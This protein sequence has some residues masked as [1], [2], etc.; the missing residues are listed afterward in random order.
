MGLA[1]AALALGT[2]IGVGTA[3][4]PIEQFTPVLNIRVGILLLLAAGSIVHYFWLRSNRDTYP[5]IGTVVA[6]CRAAVILIGFEL[7][8]AEIH[9]F[10]RHQSGA[11]SEH[12]AGN[13]G[14]FIEIM[15]FAT[16]WM[17]YSFP[18]VRYGLRNRALT[19]LLAGLGSVGVAT[20][21][22]AIAAFA[23]VPTGWLSLA[24]SLRPIVLLFLGAGLFLHMRWLRE[25]QRAYRWLDAV[26]VAM[27]A[28]TVLLGF[29]LLTAQTRDAVQ[30]QIDVA[31]ARGV[32]S[33]VDRWQNLQQV[34]L[35]VIWLLYAIG[36]LI[37]GLWR[38]TRWIRL[39][40]M[41]LLGFIILK[42]FLYDL[43]FLG[44]A[45]R[46]ISFA[47]LGVILLGVSYLYQRYR[48][49]LFDMS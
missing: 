40:A 26:L 25:G 18:L 44:P 33:D 38:R 14:L 32:P 35:S 17:L 46:S 4:Q 24:L 1:I 16:V 19:V 21:A 31:Q 41:A 34:T 12:A 49:L 43:S 36:L 29:E 3:Y 47:G 39:G 10:F 8:T 37:V 15:T 7:L 27:Q 42:I 45:Y 28:A 9:D 6:A 5:W 13:S 22:G 48:A 23:Y 11:I 30:H 20:G 2:G